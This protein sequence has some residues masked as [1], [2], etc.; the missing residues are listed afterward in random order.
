MGKGKQFDLGSGALNHVLGG[1][2]LGLITEIRSGSPF[3]MI[4]NNAAICRCFADTVRTD[5][6]A[7]YRKNPNF[8][9]NVFQETYFDTSAFAAP[10]NGTFGNTGRTIAIGPGAVGADLSV[11]K[12][13]NISERQRLQLRVEMLNFINK[14]NF[15]LPNQNRGNSNFGFIRGTDNGL[16]PRI[17]QVG[18]HYKF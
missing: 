18:L 10:A 15:D 7:P 6:I 3:G 11:L 9:D 4:E 1:W 8:R 13:V 14:T 5:A 17:I 12:D 2:S 16:G